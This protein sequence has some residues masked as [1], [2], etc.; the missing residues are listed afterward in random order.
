MKIKPI[1]MAFSVALLAAIINFLFAYFG[2]IPDHG[3]L[4]ELSIPEWFILVWLLVAPWHL[5]RSEIPT[6]WWCIF[7]LSTLTLMLPSAGDHIFLTFGCGRRPWMPSEQAAPKFIAVVV[8][9]MVAPVIGDVLRIRRD[10][11]R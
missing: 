7:G 2:T 8:Y 9:S 4:L 1:A 11:R 6:R 3:F 5:G 10:C